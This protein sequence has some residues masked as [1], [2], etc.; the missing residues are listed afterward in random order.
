MVSEGSILFINDKVLVDKEEDVDIG[1]SKYGIYVCYFVGIMGVY[2]LVIFLVLVVSFNLLF[3]MEEYYFIS[4]N[5][6]IMI[7]FFFLVIM[8][9][10]F[11]LNWIVG[12]LKEKIKFYSFLS[13]GI[14]LVLIWILFKEWVIVLGCILV[15]LGYGVI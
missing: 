7:F 8:I 11:F 5:F 12:I 1:N 4:G 6:G 2:G 10:G 13:I 9:F 15:G 14:G 3:L